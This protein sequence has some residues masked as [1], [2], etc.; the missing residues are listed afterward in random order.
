MSL[1]RKIKSM[2]RR[3]VVSLSLP[4]TGDYP[5]VQIS[6]LG[7]TAN[8]EAIWPYGMGGRL[9]VDAQ[10]FC[11]NIEG[12]EENKAGIGTTPTLRFKVNEEGEVYFGNPLTGSVTYYR[13][14]GDIEIIGKNNKSVTLDGNMD[15]TVSGNSTET[16]TGD[17]DIISPAVNLGDLSGKLL[18]TDDIIALFNSHTHIITAIGTPSATPSVSYSAAN[19]TVKTKAS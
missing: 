12:M 1:L 2:I 19:A 5:I 8:A 16:V 10:V 11:F 15:V 9:P 14:N 4:D 6:Y 13:S 18:M 3:A 17:K 7:K